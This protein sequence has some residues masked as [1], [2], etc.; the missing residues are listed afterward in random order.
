MIDGIMFDIRALVYGPT[1]SDFLSE[2]LQAEGI[3]TTPDEVAQALTRLPHELE[4][5]RSNMRDEEQEN[6]YN[7]AMLPALLS[8]LGLKTPSDALLFRLVETVYDYSAYFSMYPETLPVLQS[9]KERG[10]KLVVV[11]NWAPSLHRMVAAFELG[12]LLTTIVSSAVVGAAKPDGFFFHR[13]LKQ[14]GL[15]ADEVLHVGPSMQEDVAGASAAGIRPVW[16]NRLAIPTN[17]DVLS[18]L[19]LRGLLLLLQQGAD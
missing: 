4:V 5:L 1:G 13:A 7:R 2:V 17:H 8:H 6:E 15:K 10:L 19:D 3:T 14:A 12:E 16:L 9:L 11:G 18:I